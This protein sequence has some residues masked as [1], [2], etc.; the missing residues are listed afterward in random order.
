MF[1]GIKVKVP[2]NIAKRDSHPEPGSQRA[3]RDLR[4]LDRQTEVLQTSQHVIMLENFT[5]QDLIFVC[6]VF[7]RIRR[8]RKSPQYLLVSLHGEIVF[9]TI[10]C[11]TS[12]ETAEKDVEFLARDNFLHHVGSNEDRLPPA[13]VPDLRQV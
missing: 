9:S 6:A 3:R 5:S 13:E 7:A 2:I 8:P 4:A 11:K 12:A 1:L 10:L